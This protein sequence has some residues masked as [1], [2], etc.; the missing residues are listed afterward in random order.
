LGLDPER[1]GISII[2]TG[3]EATTTAALLEGAIDGAAISYTAAMEPKARG[4]HSWD[5]A[6]LGIAEIT[7]IV[8]R[9]GLLREKPEE[10]RRLLRA[11]AAS[12]AY[13]RSIGT[14]GEARQRVGQAVANH[15][16]TSPESVLAQL[17]LVKDYLP[18]DLRIELSEAREQQAMTAVVSPEV[19]DQRVEDWLDQSFLDQLQREGF[20]D[21]LV[22]R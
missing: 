2:I 11:L 20:F 19:Q 22:R 5:L 3:D 9:P 4:F 18:I 1:D 8:A 7:G 17:D 16:R 15:L 21:R 10:T 12:N 13:I 14:D 6:P